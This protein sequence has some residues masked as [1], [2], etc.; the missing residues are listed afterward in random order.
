MLFQRRQII[1]G[2][3]ATAVFG[4]ARTAMAQTGTPSS[5]RWIAPWASATT[6]YPEST[7]AI[8]AEDGAANR[9]KPL[10]EKDGAFSLG[11][12]GQRLDTPMGQG[13]ISGDIWPSGRVIVVH[14]ARQA[15]PVGGKVDAE[16]TNT[17]TCWRY[18]DDG[19]ST[20]RTGQPELKFAGA[21]IPQA[22]GE[23]PDYSSIPYP[24]PWSLIDPHLIRLKNGV[25]LGMAPYVRPHGTR[26]VWGRLIANPEDPREKWRMGPDC[27]VGDGFIH[28]PA[29]LDNG[30]LVGV[31]AAPQI[32]M[33]PP[34]K[35]GMIFGHYQ[36]DFDA[37][38]FAFNPI[39]RIP[40]PD[41]A[42]PPPAKTQNSFGET[43]VLQTSATGLTAIYRRQGGWNRI[44]SKDLGYS[45]GRPETFTFTHLGQT[46]S[47]IPSRMQMTRG[48]DGRVYI[49]MN[50]PP[51]GR[52]SRENIVLY[53]SDVG[54]EGTD[55]PF[56]LLIHE[57][58][59]DSYPA[60]GFQ[61]TPD[62]RWTGWM[63]VFWDQGRG[64]QPENYPGQTATGF[65][66]RL[67]CAR[68]FVPPL[69]KGK[70]QAQIVHSY[71][72]S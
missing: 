65:L 56:R 53:A 26:S 22:V 60:F 44:H 52:K 37:L 68:V 19:F 25:A 58:R 3:G 71:T 42:M 4:G 9:W 48:P 24:S 18:S 12:K 14:Q 62:D 16:G 33:A 36:F 23:W 49:V 34:Y 30:V 27:Y 51:P 6:G 54:G 21:Y 47:P 46:I 10:W 28:R 32:N 38:T 31:V 39:S 50:G 15:V 2:L 61:M 35:R 69:F 7:E 70:G 40:E 67:H 20:D 17:Y 41:E 29:W 72:D 1:S 45:W 11:V 8:L 57:E 55:F 66:N 63:A 13:L 59:R 5:P 64:V 43:S